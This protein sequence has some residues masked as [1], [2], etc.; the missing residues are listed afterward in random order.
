VHV[1]DN[2]AAGAVRLE[3]ATLQEIDAI[4]DAAG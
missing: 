1:R 2:A 3:D 4:L